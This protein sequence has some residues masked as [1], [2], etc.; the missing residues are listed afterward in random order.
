MKNIK[1]LI[2]SIT[3][4]LLVIAGIGTTV[5]VVNAASDQMGFFNEGDFGI[6]MFD[7]DFSKAS[8]MNSAEWTQYLIDEGAI[9]KDEGEIELAYHNSNNDAEKQRL[10]EKL[11][12]L[13]FSKGYITEEEAKY[14]KSLRHDDDLK[15]LD[16]EV[17]FE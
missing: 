6:E 3:L 7:V 1:K 11:I 17:I 13:Q 2:T 12:D 10:Y 15:N 16:M 9:S 14:S 8:T 5:K 4:G